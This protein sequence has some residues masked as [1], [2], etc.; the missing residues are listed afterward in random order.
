MYNAFASLVILLLASVI[1]KVCPPDYSERIISCLMSYHW[2]CADGAKVALYLLSARGCG[3]TLG[4]CRTAVANFTSAVR[5]H[6]LGL[7]TL[8]VAVDC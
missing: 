4:N 8:K 7:E 6:A 5:L 1:P 3:T 2:S